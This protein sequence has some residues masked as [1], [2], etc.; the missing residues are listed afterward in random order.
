MHQLSDPPVITENLYHED[1]GIG[2]ACIDFTTNHNRVYESVLPVSHNVLASKCFV[3]Q[4][5][6]QI[7]QLYSKYAITTKIK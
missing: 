7:K 2:L 3:I 6:R 1:K 4:L 5:S